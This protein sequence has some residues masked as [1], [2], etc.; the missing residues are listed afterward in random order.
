MRAALPRLAAL[1]SAAIATQI[2][3]A[4]V[5]HALAREAGLENW[6]A[7]KHKV[8]SAEPFIHQVTRFLGALGENDG[9]TMRQVLERFPDVARSSLHAACAA[10]DRPAAE[11]WLARE[12]SQVTAGIGRTSSWTPLVCPRAVAIVRD[13]QA[14]AAARRSDRRASPGDG[15]GRQ[16]VHAPTR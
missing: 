1:D 11:A 13:R 7:L 5:Q 12:P 10:C 16:H 9:D 15:R 2:K 14:H 3:L 6:A 4:D 8:E